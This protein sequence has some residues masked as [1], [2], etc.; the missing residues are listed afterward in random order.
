V[1]NDRCGAPLCTESRGGV[2]GC[3]KRTTEHLY[4]YIS[5]EHFI[6]CAEDGGCGTFANLFLETVSSRNEIARL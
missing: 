5:T 4:R 2:R 1:R 6:S 3:G